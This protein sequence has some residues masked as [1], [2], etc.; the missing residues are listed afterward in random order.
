M[1]KALITALISTVLIIFSQSL[2]AEDA[3][4]EHAAKG[5]D[6]GSVLVHHLMDAPVIEWNI[7]GEKVYR[8]DDRF[9]DVPFLKSYV[10]HDAKGDYRWVG[11]IPMHITKR[12]IMMFIVAFFM[13]VIFIGGA[14]AIS[15]SPFRVNGKIA[16]MIES[17]V[18]YIRNDV[19][20]SN[21]HHAKAYHPFF[22]SLFFFL[23]FSNLFGLIPSPTVLVE[24][25][26]TLAAGH[27]GEH[28]HGIT[29]L[30]SLW[31]GITVTGDIAVTAVFA[32]S[33]TLMIW[34]VGFQKQG[35]G[36]IV[37]CIPHG[38][39][40]AIGIPLFF[41]LFP[42]ELIIGPLAKG[43]ALAVRLL[44]NMTAGHVIILALLGFI[45]QFQS[46]F[47]APVSILGAGAIF[48]LELLVAFIQAFVFTLLTAIF[49]GSSM[50]RH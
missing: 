36:F 48:G 19:V 22:L 34:I 50:H 20:D 26:G 45:F 13:L 46:Y 1:K 27:A 39:S 17:M 11:G 23:L 29:F 30:E 16:G 41:I 2:A 33:V 12:V 44:A 49:I 40:P 15:K 37:S 31:P 35:L 10:F 28:G 21:M 8:G 4:K 6:L 9:K 43:F 3:S 14:R 25:I 18:G 7:G 42:L 38:I 24:S 5:F 47:V 32:L